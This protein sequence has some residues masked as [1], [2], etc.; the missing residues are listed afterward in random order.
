MHV[1]P[2][3]RHP[4]TPC[5]FIHAVTV[6]VDAMD[7]DLVVFYYQVQGDIDQLQLPA[8]QRSAHADGLWHDTCFEA[9]IHAGAT[10]AYYELNFSP[11]SAW[12]VYHFDS[13][14]Q[15]MRTVEPHPPPKIICRRREDSLEADVDVRR[16]ALPGLGAGGGDPRLAL[17][18]ILNDQHGGRSYWALAHPPGPPD[19]HH[20]DSFAVT[21]PLVGEAR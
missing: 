5:A 4:A 13:Y 14:R 6:R 3:V 12:A 20:A 21:L 11:S 7:D 10:G 1:L 19:F 8:Q 18:V 17:A 15:G 16:A 2:L 9:F